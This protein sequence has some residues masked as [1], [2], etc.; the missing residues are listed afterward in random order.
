MNRELKRVSVVVLLLFLALFISTTVIQAV[1]ADALRADSRN[2]RTLYES[3]QVE[4]GPILVA[5]NPIAA[6]TAVDDN[7]KWQRSYSSGVLYAPV[8]GFFPVN[9]AAT[10]IE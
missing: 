8:T 1:S 4:R 6:S 5:G 2:T 10:G 3:Y 7:Y 9:G